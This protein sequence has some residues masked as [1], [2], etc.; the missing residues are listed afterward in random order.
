MI[1]MALSMK[2]LIFQQTMCIAR[3]RDAIRLKNINYDNDQTSRKNSSM[4]KCLKPTV[5]HNE[6]VKDAPKHNNGGIFQLTLDSIWK[7]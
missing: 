7:V 5:F 6:T 1:Y 4:K 2:M 3:F